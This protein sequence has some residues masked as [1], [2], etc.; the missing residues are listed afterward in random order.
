MKRIAFLWVVLCVFGMKK[1][2]AE[3]WKW[4]NPQTEKV[5]VIQNQ[6]FLNEI[7]NTYVRLPLRAKEVVRKKVWDLSRHSAGL[8]IEF[9][10]NSPELLVRYAVV[11]P[12]HRNHMPATGVSGIDLYRENPEGEWQICHGSYAFGDTISYKYKLDYEEGK[13]KPL[14]YKLFLPLYNEVK[15][16]GIGI[17][18]SSSLQ[19][20]PSCLE[21]PI[22]VYGT[23]IVQGACASRPA[24]A[25]TT[26]LHRWL[27]I[28]VIN[29]GFSG[30]GKLE[31]NVLD[32][33]NEIDASM[34]VLDCMPNLTELST[35]QVTQ[36]V[37]EAV[38]QI[39]KK[40]NAPI[41]LV[42]HLGY[43][44]MFTNKHQY[45]R[46]SHTNKGAEDAYQQIKKQ[47]IKNVF[48]L[49][50]DDI[51]IPSDG[52]VDTVHPSDYGMVHL[53]RIVKTKICRILNISR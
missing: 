24:M 47:G 30:N 42:E 12:I 39:R 4:F 17:Q 49:S 20:L 51:D 33:L 8:F 21:K 45:H 16:L 7:G 11:D 15:W 13:V 6:A 9:K 44:N 22:V 23:S 37:L 10:T 1:M 38:R 19:F 41:L 18:D 40:H 43:S 5:S 32:F 25:W 50:S 28:P 29:M 52:R 2:C 53:A 14:S 48:Y 35:E 34:F 3:S 46:F 31:T 26:I 27:D 36:R